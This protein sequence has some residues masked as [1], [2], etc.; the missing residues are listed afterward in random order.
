MKMQGALA[1]I[2]YGHRTRTKEGLT[3]IESFGQLELLPE[4][5]EAISGEVLKGMV[6]LKPTPIQRLAIPALIGQ[7][8]GRRRSRTRNSPD[9]K[10]FMLAAETGSGKTL[11]YLLPIVNAIKKEENSDPAIASY[12]EY[13]AKQL[14]AMEDPGYTG[15]REFE[16]HPTMARP[17]AIVLVPSAELVDQVGR[18]AKSISHVAKFKSSR[19]SA[20]VPAK[21]INRDMY[22]PGGIDLIVSTPHL[23]A[24]M[25]ESDPH[26][27]S[28]VRSLVVDEADSLFDRSFAPI[29][30][31]LI[32]RALP[33]LK[34]LILCSATIPKGLD[35]YV[36]Q[37][38]PDMVRLT[39]PNLHAIPRRVQLGVIDVS[40]DPYRNNKDLACADAI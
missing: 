22:S 33:S 16:P 23:L 4:V 39:T 5:K 13:F 32:D 35:N 28:R 36:A 17:K 29:T 40:K 19:F 34:Q 18:V 38:F 3:E 27:L 37:E 7:D 6:D 2:P 14:A 1:T 10:E 31:A 20:T 30:T 25:A 11:A 15:P 26:I 24:S 9:R 12:R 21:V 8:I